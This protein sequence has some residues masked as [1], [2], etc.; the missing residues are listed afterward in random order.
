MRTCAEINSYNIQI[1][2]VLRR[3][4]DVETNALNQTLVSIREDR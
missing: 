3:E 2:P 1:T 4:A